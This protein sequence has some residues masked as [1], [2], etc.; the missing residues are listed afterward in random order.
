MA[1]FSEVSFSQSYVEWWAKRASLELI[2]DRRRLSTNIM[3]NNRKN[4]PVCYT[5]LKTKG[6]VFLE[7]LV[8]EMM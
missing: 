5:G 7:S 3:N 8:D 2:F 4:L 1:V 6:N